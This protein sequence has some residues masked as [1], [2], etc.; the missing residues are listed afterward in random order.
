MKTYVS[1]FKLIKEAFREVLTRSLGVCDL[2]Y[3]GLFPL[4]MF[5]R[6]F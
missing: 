4:S 1:L 3:L 2:V 6:R 5:L